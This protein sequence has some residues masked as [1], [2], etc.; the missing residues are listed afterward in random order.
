[1]NILSFCD[2]LGYEITFLQG[3]NFEHKEK[4]IGN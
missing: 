2:G 1:M 3:L 4:L